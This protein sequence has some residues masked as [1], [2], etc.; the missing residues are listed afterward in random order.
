MIAIGVGCFILVEAV[1]YDLFFKGM[2]MQRVMRLMVLA[3]GCVVGGQIFGSVTEVA[4]APE[5]SQQEYVFLMQAIPAD[6]EHG[7]FGKLVGRTGLPEKSGSPCLF[8]VYQNSHGLYRALL[9]KIDCFAK[10]SQS[11]F[12]CDALQ[13]EPVVVRDM[14]YDRCPGYCT[15]AYFSLQGAVCID[16]NLASGRMSSR[17]STWTGFD[18]KRTYSAPVEVYEFET[19]YDEAGI[20][21]FEVH[22]F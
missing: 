15:I 11:I 6:A 9:S 21:T 1:F 20:K 13:L 17:A 22:K 7:F 19:R 14:L 10:S 18:L 3:V 16:L 12:Y 4:P 2:R 8:M 5:L